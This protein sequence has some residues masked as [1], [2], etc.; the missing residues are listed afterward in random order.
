MNIFHYSFF[1]LVSFTFMFYFIHTTLRIRKKHYRKNIMTDS[2]SIQSS[3]DVK[4]AHARLRSMAKMPSETVQTSNGK[5]LK[6]SKIFIDIVPILV[7]I[8][9][10]S[11]NLNII[12][13]RELWIIHVLV[14]IDGIIE[15]G[16]IYV[17]FTKYLIRP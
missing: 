10:L 9:D 12:Q 1:L 5:S 15:W 16:S 8:P 6:C 4:A 13:R 17:N 7:C 11:L 3:P 2:A 14:K